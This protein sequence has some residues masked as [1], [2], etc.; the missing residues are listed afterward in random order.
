MVKNR[1][2]KVK[3]NETGIKELFRRKLEGA[4]IMPGPSVEAE[5]MKKLARK[6]FVRFNPSRF[7]IYYTGLIA[8]AAI[9]SGILLF[10]NGKANDMKADDKIKAADSVISNTLN[11]PYGSV[12]VVPDSQ[13]AAASPAASVA[14][15][16]IAFAEVQEKVSPE[17]ENTDQEKAKD[18]ISSTKIS[19]SDVLSGITPVSRAGKLR[20][21]TPGAAPLFEATTYSGCKPLKIHFRSN[22]D[23][24]G[25]F[26][27]NFGDGGYSPKKETDWIFDV[28]GEYR[29]VLNVTTADGRNLSQSQI[30]TVYPRPVARFEISPENPVIPDDEIKFLNFSTN[31]LSYN[32]SFG[33]GTGSN[34]FE[35]KHR[36][37]KFG[38]YDI[39]LSVVSENGCTDSLIIANAFSGSEYFI[40]MPNAFIPNPEGPSGGV[41]SS[42]SDESAEIFHPNFS[43]VAEYQLRIF[44]RKSILIFESN[45]VNIGWDGYFKGQ[46]SNPGVYIW[47]I[48]GKFANGEPF[49]KMGDVTLLKN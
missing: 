35:P 36:Y 13:K 23:P 46:L 28:E 16:Q 2:L 22:A 30:I 39:R 11:I 49:I 12:I 41:F 9:T 38:N 24:S 32:W 8:A 29:V 37:Q 48:R 26:S 34:L 4:E 33:D 7:N 25:T 40:D 5:L 18:A 43:G 15:K 42:K 27:W 17:P 47:K 6:E 20:E 10:N 14:S 44:S 31:A 21:N 45:D 3:K 1:E 19:Q